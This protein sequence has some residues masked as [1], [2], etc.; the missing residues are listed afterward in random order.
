MGNRGS[1]GWAI[2]LTD[3]FGSAERLC[4]D[5]LTFHGDLGMRLGILSALLGG[6]LIIPPLGPAVAEGDGPHGHI[7]DRF[8]SV[9]ADG[10][11]KITLDDI[12][13]GRAERFAEADANGD[14]DL[15]TS[16]N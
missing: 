6:A 9:D 15:S 2:D 8:E 1:N 14:G 11:G 12:Q 10:D 5:A 4:H 3:G 16:R 13:D 7:L